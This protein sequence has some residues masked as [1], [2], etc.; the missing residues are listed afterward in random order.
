LKLSW[1]TLE[2]LP[3]R[4]RFSLRS[5]V[6]FILLAASAVAFWHHRGPWAGPV[7]LNTK[8]YM[9]RG[10]TFSSDGSRIL[11]WGDHD[12]NVRVWDARTGELLSFLTGHTSEVVR[13]ALSP[14]D[15]RVVA[16]A[17]DGTVKIWDMRTGTVVCTLPPHGTISSFDISPGGK[18]LVTTSLTGTI[19]IWNLLSGRLLATMGENEAQGYGAGAYLS[20]DGNRL[21]VTHAYSARVWS[22]GDRTRIAVIDMPHWGRVA[23][24][25][26]SPDGKIVYT[27][28]LD[29]GKV[30]LWRAS[31][32]QPVLTLS[33][34][35]GAQQCVVFF[36]D[37]RR[38]IT[39]VND[40]TMTIT[41]VQTQ[42]RLALLEG[43][44]KITDFATL[45]PDATRIVTASQDGTARIWDAETGA[46]LMVIDTD[47]GCC[48]SAPLSP[49]ARRMIMV[50]SSPTMLLW[51][52]RRPEWW[53][54]VAWLPSFWATVL[55]A[56]L[57]AWSFWCDRLKDYH[58]SVRQAA[59]NAL[60]K[61]RG[62]GEGGAQ[63]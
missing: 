22:L 6:I 33:S 27:M 35:K 59:A 17:E 44:T 42:Q 29:D 25:G 9:G 46:C 62:E 56:G 13:V 32:G 4:L 45:Y 15:T 16:K 20:P 57:L 3:R 58:Q 24:G 28:G 18:Q 12:N 60:K 51:R 54:G 41:D 61:I 47:M 7:F 30:K 34:R 53:W 11:A 26:F 5:L 10:A 2:R 50:T 23:G 49:D 21:L 38:V 43:H 52:W 55:F 1:K 8:W 19:Q 40:S 39:K 48:Y 36:P 37:S 14:D 31:S 63:E